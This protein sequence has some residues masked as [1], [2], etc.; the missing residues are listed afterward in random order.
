MFAV[1]EHWRQ[2][3]CW[4]QSRQVPDVVSVYPVMHWEQ[5]F[6]VAAQ[7]WQLVGVVHCR[8]VLLVVKV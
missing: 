8:H 7:A 6:A 5:T 1:V 2:L 4:V 3:G